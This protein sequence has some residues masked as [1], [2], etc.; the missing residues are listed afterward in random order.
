MSELNNISHVRT[1]LDRKEFDAAEKLLHSF[2]P[3]TKQDMRIKEHFLG[4][5]EFR[6]GNLK[7]ALH[8]FS[9]ARAKYGD[10]IGLTCDMAFTY[11]LMEDFVS[12]EDCV[13]RATKTFPK[14]RHKMES[15]SELRTAL[16][17]ARFN[18]TTGD[19]VS[20]MD[21]CELCLKDPRNEPHV[22]LRL[23]LQ[24]QL[25]R[26]QAQFRWPTQELNRYYRALLQLTL[27]QDRLFHVI[28]GQHSLMLAEIHILGFDP[29]LNRLKTILSELELNESDRRLCFFDFLIE[30][31][32]LDF[33]PQVDGQLDELF[34]L[35]S[36][37]P[38]TEFEKQMMTLWKGTVE[39]KSSLAQK[40]MLGNGVGQTM[41]AQERI[42][43]LSL[44]LKTESHE[45]KSRQ[46][47]ILLSSLPS[48]G[49]R[50]WRGR[51]L[52]QPLKFALELN[53]EQLSCQNMT[54]QVSSRSTIYTLLKALAETPSMTLEQVTEK[55]WGETYQTFHYER[56]RV[57]TQRLN[58]TLKKITGQDRLVKFSKQQISLGSSL[59][60]KLCS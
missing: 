34:S 40:N 4:K 16:S 30:M 47:A 13:S 49:Q 14:I 23:L 10:Y 37:D 51:V 19:V 50:A 48:E 58:R 32:L 59:R 54:I 18:E 24:A 41:T 7:A 27:T 17:I 42:T 53:G 44:A 6:K 25:L 5:V 38:L 28:D 20:A 11:Y 33:L 22:P 26:L 1:L 3:E 57:A 8:R 2:S 46:L 39:E 31:L 55:I 43:I 15:E 60:L 9:D 21:I 45:E 56:L 35:L 12:F 29:A 36:S 52:Q